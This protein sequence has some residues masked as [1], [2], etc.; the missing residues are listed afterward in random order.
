MD[1]LGPVLFV[2]LGGVIGLVG[3]WVCVIWGSRSFNSRARS[4]QQSPGRSSEESASTETDGWGEAE[5]LG[6]TS[7]TR[8]IETIRVEPKEYSLQ[9]IRRSGGHVVAQFDVDFIADARAL[10]DCLEHQVREEI[11]GFVEEQ[12]PQQTEDDVLERA[13]NQ[14]RQIVLVH[15]ENEGYQVADIR[16][17]VSYGLAHVASEGHGLELVELLSHQQERIDP[18]ALGSREPVDRHPAPSLDKEL[19]VPEPILQLS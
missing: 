5:H 13:G 7:L 6:F 3:A 9:I 19:E 8:R 12:A 10:C 4:A 17:G 15:T 14:H 1:A 2:I 18:L 11:A 16:D